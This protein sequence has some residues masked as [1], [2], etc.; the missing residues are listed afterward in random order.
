[1]KSISA[2]FDVFHAPSST[3]SPRNERIKEK[4]EEEEE[5]RRKRYERNTDSRARR[6]TGGG[7]GGGGIRESRTVSRKAGI[8]C[9]TRF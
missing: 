6:K 4:E 1:M 3:V 5:R 7:G 2:V 9:S 8:T